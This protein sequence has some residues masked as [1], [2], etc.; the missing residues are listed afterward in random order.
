MDFF[1]KSYIVTIN[2]YEIAKLKF[3]WQKVKKIV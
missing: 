2:N 3:K 1:N